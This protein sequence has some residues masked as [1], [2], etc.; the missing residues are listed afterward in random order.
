MKVKVVKIRWIIAYWV[1]VV[2]EFPRSKCFSKY[3]KV[4]LWVKEWVCSAV[5]RGSRPCRSLLRK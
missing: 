3:A 4:A 1:S 2:R 5:T